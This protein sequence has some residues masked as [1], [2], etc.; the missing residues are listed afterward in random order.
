MDVFKLA[1]E[2]TVVGL[3]TLSWL[4]VAACLLFPDVRLASVVLMLPDLAQKNLT[5]VGV[6]VLILAYCLGSAILPISNQLVNDEHWPLNESAIRC[7]VFTKYEVDLDIAPTGP[8][9][10]PRG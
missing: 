8:R 6:G 1:F 4:S 3:L 5:T 10:L 9:C 2:T 7:Q